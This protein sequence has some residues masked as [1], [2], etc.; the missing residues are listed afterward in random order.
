MS[1]RADKRNPYRLLLS[2]NLDEHEILV[3]GGGRVAERKIATLL[4]C[5][6]R[7]KMV[8]PDVTENLAEL[9]REGTIAWERRAAS[10]EDF[11]S[12]RF[13]V[14]AVPREA[15]GTLVSL[16]R[17]NGCAVD[18]CSGA[19]TDRGD[20][21][22][23][24]QFVSEELFVGVS[25]GGNDPSAAAAAKRRL[26]KSMKE[27][28]TVLTRGSRLAMRQAEMWIEALA[29]VGVNAAVRT[30][31]SHGDKDRRKDLSAFGFGAFVK[32]LEDELLSGRGDC[33]VHSAKDMPAALPDGC[34]L[35]AVLQRGSRRDVVVTG[36][37]PRG[38]SSG[39]EV[40]LS[41]PR[42][43]RVGTSSARRT[44]QVSSLR[45][46]IVCVPCRGN[47]ETRM[48]RLAGG[49]FD[50][51]VLAEVGLERLGLNA[52]NAY[53]LSFVTSAGQGAIAAETVAGSETEAVLRLLNHVPTWYE[54]AAERAFLSR[55]SAGCSLP[56][57]VNAS[58]DCGKMN[59]TAEIYPIQAGIEPAW[60]LVRG[61]VRSVD[62][63]IALST[64]MW[65]E[66]SELPATRLLNEW[67]SPS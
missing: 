25:G 41:L 12:H 53:P 33:A 36:A 28:M 29:R 4:G 60:A 26:M 2:L 27:T 32:A 47:I 9:V 58:Y 20:F 14:L 3:V 65:I 56:V 61:S 63:A 54:V 16:A 55:I 51:I 21:A 43:A 11:A 44:A 13:A 38:A 42:G 30:V 8:S 10:G 45:P 40:I 18:I 46:D 1:R 50:A 35:A 5:R 24:A 48:S 67:R 19:D 62:D 15:S 49:E 6:S 17:A 23:C 59:I 31:A 64:E 22:L 52:E 66:M 39:E 7:V 57:A 34:A 37:A